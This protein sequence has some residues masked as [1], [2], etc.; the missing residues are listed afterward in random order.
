[1][2]SD[3]FDGWETKEVLRERVLT[4]LPSA[5]PVRDALALLGDIEAVR[6]AAPCLDYPD[7]RKNMAGLGSL[8]GYFPHFMQVRV[9]GRSMAD[10][11]ADPSELAKIADKTVAFVQKHENGR[12]SLNRIFQSLK[13][14][15][16]HHVSNFRPVAARDLYLHLV[17]RGA[18]VL[19]PCAGWGG[20]LV[21]A[22]GAGVKRYVG[23]D[24]SRATVDGHQALIAD[25]GLTNVS[26]GHGCAEDYVP[27]AE[28]DMAFTS[29][30]YWNAEEYSED[31]EQSFKRYPSYAEWRDG[32]LSPLARMMA[33][34][35][36]VG[37]FVA[38]N[39]A[40]VKKKPICDDTKD[41]LRNAGLEY[42]ATYRYILSSVA[43]KGE[44]YEP[45]F[46]FRKRTE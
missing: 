18:S 8:W 45:V 30:P 41:A 28:F 40:D 13:V 24:A 10:K 19:D 17:G 1:M 11:L 22:T 27:D 15:N 3:I 6:V 26:V 35:V 5:L 37:G 16:G 43:G 29:P 12:I 7:L 42:H 44:K 39:V 32:F 25:A 38:L 4:A 36:R 20:R 23:I 34:A 2:Q 21:G 31:A 14:Y 9:N 46:V 33:S